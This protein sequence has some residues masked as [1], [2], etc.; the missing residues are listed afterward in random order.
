MN[1]HNLITLIG[2][3]IIMVV[4]AVLLVAGVSVPEPKEPS[5][6]VPDTITYMEAYQ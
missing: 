3:I 1:R 2:I 5:G 6:L 4:I